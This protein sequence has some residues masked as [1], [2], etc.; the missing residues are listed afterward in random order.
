LRSSAIR[1]TIRVFGN[2]Q[3]VG[4]RALVKMIARRMGVKGL[5]RNLEDG[6]VEVFAEAEEKVLDEFLKAIDVKGRPE[7]LLSLHVDRIEVYREGEPG[8][9]GPWRSYGVFEIDYGEEKP[10]PIEKDM[11]ESLEWAKLYF[12]KLVSE[13][14]S[15]RGEFR[16]YRDEFRDFRNE[17][18]DYRKEF[19][20]FRGEFRDYRGEFRDFRDESLKLSREILGEVKELRKDLK[21]ILDERLA[22]MEKD[23]AEIKAKLGLL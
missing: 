13:F 18:R 1:A 9:R 16:D 11:A 22:R 2:V 4:Y 6:S 5:I 19:K 20:D 7:D 3:A 14:G 17:F 15:L 8:Y 10:R 12:T 23:I 21:T